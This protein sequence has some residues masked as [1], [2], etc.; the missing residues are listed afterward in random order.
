MVALIQPK[1][2]LAA[3]CKAALAITNV[4]KARTETEDGAVVIEAQESIFLRV[5]IFGQ[6]FHLDI[7]RRITIDLT[8]SKINQVIA[9]FLCHL[10]FTSFLF[11]RNLYSLHFLL[12]TKKFIISSK[13][14]LS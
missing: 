12:S 14:L 4:V 9:N 6:N 11:I 8:I 13:H 1:L 7:S 2:L 3:N 5:D 10:F